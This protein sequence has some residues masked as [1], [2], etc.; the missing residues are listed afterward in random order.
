MALV[1]QAEEKEARE[2]NREV[3]GT[4]V[5]ALPVVQGNGA[6]TTGRKSSK[7]QDSRSTLQ[8]KKSEENLVSSRRRELIGKIK[9]RREL[10]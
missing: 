9:T 8:P 4:K 3:S 6:K 7:K 2:E 1:L 5:G 10:S